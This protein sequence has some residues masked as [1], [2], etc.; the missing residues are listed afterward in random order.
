MP[1]TKP[2]GTTAMTDS[3]PHLLDADK[4]VE[5]ISIERAEH[6]K[7][8]AAYMKQ[9]RRNF[10]LQHE[11]VAAILGIVADRIRSLPSQGAD[12]PGAVER[13]R[14]LIRSDERRVGKACVSTCRSRWS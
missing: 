5:A 6:E 11:T 3:S 10:A 8:Y 13:L 9:G 7:L 14:G 12:T 4:V 1:D 2:C